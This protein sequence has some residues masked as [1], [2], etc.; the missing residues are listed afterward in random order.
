MLRP[1]MEHETLIFHATYLFMSMKVTK[2][3]IHFAPK[4]VEPV[5]FRGLDQKKSG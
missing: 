5:G 2:N 1:Y 3:V 4:R